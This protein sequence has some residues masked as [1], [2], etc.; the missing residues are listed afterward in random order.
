MKAEA[1]AFGK[2]A[3]RFVDW[4]DRAATGS[5]A[6]AELHEILGALQAAAAR[7]PDRFQE[8]QLSE[9]SPEVDHK[10]AHQKARLAARKL[11]FNAYS[12]V[13]DALNESAPT[14]IMTTIEDDLGDICADLMKGLLPYDEGR[15]S[16]AVWQWRFLYW[17]HWGRH[18]V[19]AQSAVYSYLADGNWFNN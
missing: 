16:E 10:E 1:D 14:S 5:A 18:A 11:P 17:A 7:L 13:F 8:E 15:F 4:L 3:R 9:D 19:H 12:T 6:P 2:I